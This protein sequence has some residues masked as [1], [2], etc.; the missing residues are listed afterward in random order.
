[1]KRKRKSK[2]NKA[3]KGKGQFYNEQGHWKR[4]CKLYLEY[5]K[6]KK[7]NEATTLGIYV[8]EVNLSTSA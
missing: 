8:I 4:N 5:L 6:K 2:G 7:S 1:M 3:K